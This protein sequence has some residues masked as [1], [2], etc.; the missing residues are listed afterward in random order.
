MRLFENF[1]PLKLFWVWKVIKRKYISVFDVTTKQAFLVLFTPI[2]QLSY[3][4]IT[5]HE[6]FVPAAAI[7]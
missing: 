2:R 4:V 1:K 3:C 7:L 6:N 5:L